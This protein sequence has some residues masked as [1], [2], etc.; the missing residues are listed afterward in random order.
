MNHYL[1]FYLLEVFN[2]LIQ[3]QFDGEPVCPFINDLLVT[4]N[5][6]VVYTIVRSKDIFYQVKSHCILA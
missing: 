1:I 5:T 2:N 3:Y 6:N 4:G